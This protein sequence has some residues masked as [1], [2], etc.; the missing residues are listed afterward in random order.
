MLK[1][2]LSVLLAAIL[3]LAVIPY[4]ISAKT[5]VYSPFVPFSDYTPIYSADDLLKINDNP[6]GKYYL[7]NDIIIPDSYYREGGIF[8][9]N[10]KGWSPL[11]SEQDFTGV[12]DGRYYTI[13]NLYADYEGSLSNF[14]LI[15]AN[16]GSIRRLNVSVDFSA[17]FPASGS[18][19]VF[20]A[21]ICCENYGTIEYCSSKGSI[22]L[23]AVSVS[24]ERYAINLWS[25]GVC[26][27]N[28]KYLGKCY[29]EVNSKIT[30]PENDKAYKNVFSNY[31]AVCYANWATME[32]CYNKGTSLK[33]IIGAD[34]SITEGSY[35]G[36]VSSNSGTIKNCYTTGYI[37]GVN[38]DVFEYNSYGQTI[39]GIVIPDYLNN[40]F[41]NNTT[42]ITVV[43]AAYMALKSTYPGWDFDNVWEL[44]P[45]ALAPTLRK[46]QR[47]LVPEFYDFQYGGGTEENPYIILDYSQFMM[48][49]DMP[50]ASFKLGKDI[51]LDGD[52]RNAAICDSLVFNGTLDGNGYALKGYTVDADKQKTYMFYRN[53]G[54]IKNLKFEDISL[55][56]GTG[57]DS[58]S[59]IAYWN[60]GTI[61]NCYFG[62]TINIVSPNN[63]FLF[64]TIALYNYGLINKCHGDTTIVLEDLKTST[65]YV[66]AFIGRNSGLISGCDYYGKFI[67]D[68]N[69]DTKL[70]GICG[71]NINT[72][73]HNGIIEGCTV[74][75]DIAV[76]DESEFLSARTIY[77]GG[78]SGENNAV[79]K[80]CAF[81]GTLNYV[82]SQSQS[83]VPGIYMGGISAHNASYGNIATCYC[84]GAVE[85]YVYNYNTYKTGGIVAFNEG[86]ADGYTI[87]SFYSYSGEDGI[88]VSASDLT[89]P[90]TFSDFDFESR[91][92]ISNNG[93]YFPKPK[94]REIYY[95]LKPV[96]IEYKK[97]PALTSYFDVEDF[98]FGDMV[99]NRIMNNGVIE[100]TDLWDVYFT[101]P[102]NNLYYGENIFAVTYNDEEYAY[103]LPLVITILEEMNMGDI[104]ADGMVGAADLVELRKYL[105][106]TSYKTHTVTADLNQD[107]NVDIRDLVNLKGMLS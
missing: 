107:G 38:N 50:N 66:G 11:C 51:L 105:I 8:Y 54:V 30:H 27:R 106:D 93:F 53:L 100:E 4:S 62:G 80:D 16:R 58:A 64:G 19:G 59:V 43:S 24:A 39:T 85:G 96:G 87:S 92:E 69:S 5:E 102:D 55:T 74:S 32:D 6:A 23:E 81:I 3:M 99:I 12:L 61:D 26:G 17:V 95:D 89:K 37:P 79:I 83:G 103:S 101:D 28:R 84:A 52:P 97:L 7:A 33:N 15:N 90:G 68:I 77:L 20:I 22:E 82:A 47:N 88:V 18:Y 71:V 45:N 75:A 34:G 104:N 42:E 40:T 63:Y 25:S 91:W 78:I 2:I 9:N 76:V 48:I 29:N 41:T 13:Y 10:G 49:Y 94:G 65:E 56:G 14:G 36:L 1:K 35:H 73:D 86:I 57:K 67:A 72:T 98:D 60:G 21:G 70:G 46:N 31:G 44:K